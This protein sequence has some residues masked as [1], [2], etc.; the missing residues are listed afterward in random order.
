MSSPIKSFELVAD[1]RNSLGFDQTE[2]GI[3]LMSLQEVSPERFAESFHH[4][5]QALAQDFGCAER[6]TRETWEKVSPQEKS[7]F[8]AAT[9]LA[10]LEVASKTSGNEEA[11]EHEFDSHRYFAK[12]GEAEWGC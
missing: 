9:R 8:V 3:S 1:S 4:F 6:P 7:C 5:Y 12:P 2:Q 11:T 10:L